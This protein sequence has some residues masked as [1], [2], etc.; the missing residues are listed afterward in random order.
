MPGPAFTEGDSVSL[1]PIEDE[2]HEFIQRGRNHPEVRV[3][4]TDTDVHTLEDV[5]ELL[6]DADKH[7]LACARPDGEDADPTRVGVVAFT[8]TSEP[9]KSGDIMYWVAPEHQGNGYVTEATGLF[10]DYVFRECGFHK[11]TAR[12]LETNEAS[13]A[14]L[15]SLG[16]QREGTLRDE[17]LVDDALVDAHAFGL[18]ADEW[19]SD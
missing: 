15:E 11:A 7:F 12:A 4:L 8:W 17:H 18:L 14:V 6:A 13:I 3:P 10:L 19:L 16:F 9:P 1:H 2:D 5:S